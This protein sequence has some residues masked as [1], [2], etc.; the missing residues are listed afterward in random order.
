MLSHMLN[1]QACD[2]CVKK[3]G[4]LF[5]EGDVSYVSIADQVE[6]ASKFEKNMLMHAKFATYA[7]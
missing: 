6:L 4:D 1:R 3:D 7:L 2:T 5:F